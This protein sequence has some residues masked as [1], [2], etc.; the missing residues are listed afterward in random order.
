MSDP[1]KS[2]TL[3]LR[4][5]FRF[6]R[7]IDPDLYQVLSN[8]SETER[9]SLLHAMITRSALGVAMPMGKMIEA[10]P[11]PSGESAH[12]VA[13]PASDADAIQEP[14]TP[15]AS[16]TETAGRNT[17]DDTTAIKQKSTHQDSPA[18]TK[19]VVTRFWHRFKG[20]KHSQQEEQ[21]A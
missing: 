3:D 9:S 19:G 6:S 1:R 2:E 17:D 4:V 8:L 12:P 21:E 11:Q 15:M 5:R 18:K 16:P 10:I 14:I 7:L 13:S 20:T